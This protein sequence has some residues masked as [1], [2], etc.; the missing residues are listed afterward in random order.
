MPGA[1][2]PGG[3]PT[4][5]STLYGKSTSWGTHPFLEVRQTLH[6]HLAH[7]TVLVLGMDYTS[8]ECVSGQGRQAQLPRRLE[9]P[10]TKVREA[11]ASGQSLK[12]LLSPAVGA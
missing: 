2:I 9:Q 5:V 6:S 7:H 11:K 10:E 12:S 4:S 1:A 3:P 8:S